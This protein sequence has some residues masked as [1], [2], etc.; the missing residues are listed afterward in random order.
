MH[1]LL[2]IIILIVVIVV[3]VVIVTGGDETEHLTFPYYNL[4]EYVGGA[5]YCKGCKMSLNKCYTCT[6]CGICVKESGERECVPG[7]ER[8]PLYR[9]DCQMWNPYQ[10]YIPDSLPD[11]Y[12]DMF[13]DNIDIS[14]SNDYDRLDNVID[15]YD[16]YYWPKIQG[17]CYTDKWDAFK[18]YC[19]K[20][21]HYNETL[22]TVYLP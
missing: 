7:D 4:G 13:Y 2:G 20:S 16:Y 8:G 1:W 12:W 6:N 3:M 5:K 15:Y 14:F 9:K 19:G 22:P 17:G 18:T 10:N 11:P 21:K